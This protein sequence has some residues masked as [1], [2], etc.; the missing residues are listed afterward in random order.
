MGV[1]PTHPPTLMMDAVL[2][3]RTAMGIAQCVRACCNEVEGG[4]RERQEDHVGQGMHY[5]YY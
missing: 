2:N 3:Q 5:T 4:Q 1:C